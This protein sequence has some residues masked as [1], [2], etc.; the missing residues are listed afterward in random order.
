LRVIYPVETL[1]SN[2]DMERFLARVQPETTVGRSDGKLWIRMNDAQPPN[3]KVRVF[4][5][6]GVALWNSSFVQV[7]NLDIERFSVGIDIENSYNIVI[8]H[9]DI[10]QVLGMG[11]YLRSADSDC[12]VESNTV[13]HSGNTALYVLKGARNIFRDNWVSHVAT[14]VLGIKTAGDHMGIGLQESAQTLVEYND[15]AYSGGIDFYFE[16]HSTIRYNYLYRVTSAGSPHGTNLKVYGNIY[17]LSHANGEAGSTGVNAVATGP[18]TISVFNNTILNASGFFLK[19]SS[20]KG[21]QVAFSNNIAASNVTSAALLTF[22]P[23]VTS[24]HNC[25]FTPAQ[26]SFTYSQASFHSLADYQE[27]S[28]LDKD[29]V[30]ADPQF[31]SAAPV[32]PLDFR[33]SAGSGCNASALDPDLTEQNATYDYDQ[34]VSRKR[35]VGAF[36]E[37]ADKPADEFRTLCTDHCLGRS[38]DAPRGVYLVAI[39]FAAEAL[40]KTSEATFMLNGTRVV[41]NSA[42]SLSA[43]SKDDSSQYFLVRPSDSSITFEPETGADNSMITEIKI[44]RFDA[45]HGEGAQVVSW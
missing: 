6:A 8:R 31:V 45:S 38:F 23:N 1:K 2:E 28:G 42:P 7:E 35:S 37:T 25:F 43:D 36:S 32:T 19:G 21:G 26:P 12:Q 18:G 27:K 29:S 24:N 15:F 33:I 39:K 20:S 13:S 16:R 5:Y 17:N 3:E 10:R 14:S 4:E 34:A 11:I 22:G 40:S 30:F 44:L 9:N 41:A